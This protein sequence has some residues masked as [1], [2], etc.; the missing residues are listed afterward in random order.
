MQLPKIGLTMGDPS[1]VGPE[2]I[3]AAWPALGKLCR[4]LVLG[5]PG[6]MRRAVTLRHPDARVVEIT[7]VAEAEPS[8]LAV[9]CLKA[10]H[11]DAADVPP[12]QID[13][14]GGQAAYDAL[15][16][17]IE[18]A[19]RGEIDAITTAPLNKAALDRAGHHFPGHTEILAERCGM[20]EFAMMLYLPPCDALGGDAGLAAVHATLH[21]ALANVPRELSPARIESV[22]RL[23]DSAMRRLQG[24]EPRIGVCALNPHAGEAGLFGNE[25]ATLIR[26]AIRQALSGGINVVGPL[27]A[28]TLMARARDGEFDAVVCMY[29]DQGHIALKL[30]GMHRAV[31]ITLGLPI[32]RTSVAHGTAFDLAWQGV[33]NEQ[34]MIEAV[35]VAARLATPEVNVPQR[36]LPPSVKGV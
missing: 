24:G 22:I 21:T 17:A 15:V 31:N 29:H 1:G 10:C 27:P 7:G 6:V 35:R 11:H 18:L 36:N 3:A 20:N 25:E 5:H 4:P 16:C 8:V 13:P 33:A 19:R 9:P 28:D 12:R 32:V 30:L 34:S 26:P 2:I 14:R 23:S